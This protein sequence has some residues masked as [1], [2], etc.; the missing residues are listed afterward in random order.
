MDALMEYDSGVLSARTGFGK[1]V[2]AAKMIAERKINTLIL[3]HRQQLLEQWQER[4]A[5]FL[6]LTKEQMGAVKRMWPDPISNQ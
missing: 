3:V 6:G 5:T 1:T 4:L 2:I